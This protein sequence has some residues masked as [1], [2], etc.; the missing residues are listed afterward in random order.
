MMDNVPH[1]KIFDRKIPEH[2]R[3]I[4]KVDGFQF[5]SLVVLCSLTCGSRLRRSVLVSLFLLKYC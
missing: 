2:P 4:S 3:V 5:N 1:K